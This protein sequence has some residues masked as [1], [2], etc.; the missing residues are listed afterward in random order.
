MLH[1]ERVASSLAVLEQA[2]CRGTGILRGVIREVAAVTPVEPLEREGERRVTFA[3]DQPEYIPLPTSID[4]RGCVT[5]EWEPTED[6]LHTLLCGGRI[7]LRV[8]T[9][10]PRVGQPGH[11]LQPI[12]LD[13]L[14]PECGM[15]E[16]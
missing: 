16:S 12:S 8:L 13:V 14:E 5:T 6:E 9:F 10:D 11:E 2:H 3:E 1:A 7:R 4:A 15:R